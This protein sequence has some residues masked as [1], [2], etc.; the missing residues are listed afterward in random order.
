MPPIL[1]CLLVALA[2][3][4]ERRPMD[5]VSVQSEPV[6]K[7]NGK[8][9]YQ[10]D[11]EWYLP[12]DYRSSLTLEERREYF[13]RWVTTEL[14]YQAANDAGMG[15]SSEIAAKLEQYKKDL[16]ADQLV[17]K[18]IDDR[19]LVTEQEVRAYYLEREHEYTQE[20]RVSHILVNT[21]EDAEEV[22]ELLEKRTFSWVATRRSIDRHTGIGG[23]LGYLSKGNMIPAFEPVVFS[24]EEGD[25]SDIV[26]SELG[27]HFIKLVDVR[28]KR[29]KM[30]YDEVAP[31]ISRELLLAKRAAV[32]DSLVTSLV[33][34]AR[35]EVL[36]NQLRTGNIDID[37]E[38]ATGRWWR[39]QQQ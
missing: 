17:Q 4:C 19:G 39:Q 8:T 27:F 24:M 5:D 23:D 6:A 12:Q 7:V 33:E 31:D 36:D 10:D 9:L 13:D 29:D 3:G 14:L 15:V 38:T 37:T 28:E 35:V 20:Y 18:V 34:T 16:V 22:A 11:F 21:L 1:L 32:Y 2:L 26:E 30:T 25:V